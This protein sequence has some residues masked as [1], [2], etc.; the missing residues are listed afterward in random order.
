M[1][2]IQ[3]YLTR[4]YPDAYINLKRYNLMFK[5]YP[6]EAQFMGPDPAVLHRLADSAR[7]I[8]EHTPEVRLITTDWEPQ[9]PVLSI[10]YD[11]AAA[12]ALGSQPQRRKHVPAFRHTAA[13]PSGSSTKASTA[14]TST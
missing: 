1:D 8:M 12:R 14:T 13:Y 9:I 6:I 11:Q 7:Y 5:K 10:E 3:E 4:R 2:E